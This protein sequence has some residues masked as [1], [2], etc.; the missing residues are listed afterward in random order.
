MIFDVKEE[1][2]FPE[3]IITAVRKLKN[4]R[5]PEVDGITS[6]MLKTTIRDCITVRIE[7]LTQIWSDQKV[8]RDWTKETIIK[9]FSKADT[10][11]CGT[12][13]GINIISI[14]SKFMTIIILQ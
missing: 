4:G 9:L 6:E 14:P 7:L 1:P 13:R 12:W 11:V 3:E 5:M 10:L 8:P 2:P